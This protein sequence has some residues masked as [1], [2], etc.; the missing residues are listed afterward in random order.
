MNIPF[1]NF[2]A[3]HDEEFLNDIKKKFADILDHNSFIE[4]EYNTHF[5]NEFAK[6]QGAK[7]CLLVANGTDALEISLLAY[8]IGQGDLVAVP[9]MTFYASVEAIIN[10]GATPY[11]VDIDK[12]TG[13]LCP[14]A[15]KKATEEKNIKAVLPVHL[16]GAP[17]EMEEI[18]KIADAKSIVILS[19]I[20]ISEPTRPY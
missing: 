10:V 12:S 1:Y 18:Q 7:H 20:H 5:E 4:G 9:G 3:L 19:L 14:H 15:F 13:L 6:M 8:G 11:Y 2:K 17:C 16:F